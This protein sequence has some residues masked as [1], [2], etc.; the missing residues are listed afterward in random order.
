MTEEEIEKRISICEERR[1]GYLEVGNTKRADK[2][3]N[4]IYKWERLLSKLEPK[5]DEQLRDY[6]KG[7]DRL[8]QENEI[9]FELCMYALLPK[10]IYN[11]KLATDT[12]Q[13]FM[14]IIKNNLND[15][16]F[17]LRKKMTDY[18]ENGY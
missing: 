14:N 16:T 17:K 2:Y 7:Y 6:K 5:R 4:E 10:H 1:R 13:A 18:W 12:K 9:L 3:S 11:H 8:Q 15:D